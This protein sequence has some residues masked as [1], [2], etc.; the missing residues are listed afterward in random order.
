MSRLRASTVA[1]GCLLLFAARG[2]VAQEVWQAVHT[3]LPGDIVRENDVAPKIPTG[4]VQDALPST[5]PIVGLKVRRRLYAG[6]DVAARD[7]GTPL[8]VKAGSTIT[9]L[10]KSGDLSLELEARALDPGSVGDEIRVLNPASL[11]TIRGTV[12]GEGMV[13]VRSEQ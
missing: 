3:L 4:R 10:W 9:V 5:T 12:V 13:E 2:A 8:V 1:A 7:V 6:H 11:R